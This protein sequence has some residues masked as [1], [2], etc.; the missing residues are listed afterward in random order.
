MK[1]QEATILYVGKAKNLKKR[2]KQYFIPGRDGRLMVPY[3]TSQVTSIDTIVTFSEKEALLLENT[4]IKK[5]K[6]KYNVLLKDDKTFIS[7]TINHRHTW[8]M[9]KLVR[10]KENPKGEGLVF[11]PFTSAYAARQTL[12][13]MTHIFPLRQ[14]SDREFA[15]RK[16]PC[17]LYSIKRCI[18]PCVGKCTK[19]EYD[20]T[21]KRAIDFLQ[22]N[23]KKVVKELEKEMARASENLQ[24]EKAGQL[25]KTIKQIKHV[26]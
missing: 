3:L 20:V 1:D 18:A 2:V 5:H 17:L 21:V 10:Y 4:L 7:L 13:L 24:F 8:P 23:D 6:P 16:R 12:E 22:G 25:L 9:V 15:S 19:D 11:G 14:C 26:T